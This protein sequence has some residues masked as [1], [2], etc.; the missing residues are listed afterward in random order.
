MMMAHTLPWTLSSPCPILH[1]PIPC[2]LPHHLPTPSVNGFLAPCPTAAPSADT[3]HGAE[4]TRLNCSWP[5]NNMGLNTGPPAHGFFSINIELASKPMGFAFAD[6]TN[7]GSCTVYNPWWSPWVWT[8]G[9]EG[10]T[11][12]LEHLTVC[13]RPWNESPWIPRDNYNWLAFT[14]VSVPGG[15]NVPLSQ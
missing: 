15:S 3:H 2:H 10:L 6:W 13:G 5:L 8:H 14:R 4:H 12:G 11:I 9:F 1:Q 7:C